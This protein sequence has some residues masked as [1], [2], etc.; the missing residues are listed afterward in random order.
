MYKFVIVNS[1][2]VHRQEISF[3]SE[4]S[5]SDTGNLYFSSKPKGVTW[6]LHM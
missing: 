5:R 6:E 4:F 1:T 2:H 3:L